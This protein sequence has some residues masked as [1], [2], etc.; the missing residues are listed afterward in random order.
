[1]AVLTGGWPLIDRALS[2]RE[3]LPGGALLELGPASGTA[4][5]RVVGEGWSLSKAQS[6]PS[7]SYALSRDGVDV[8]AGYVDLTTTEAGAGRL[9]TGLRRV[10]SVADADS[11]LGA[12]HS[13][14]SAGGARGSTGTLTRGGRTGTATVWLR[15]DETCAVEITV[16]AKPG[17]GADAMAEA[18]ALVRGVSFPQEAG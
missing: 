16:L 3:R 6:D 7:F 5:L 10:Q 15:P 13:A 12:P 2:D 18:M 8:V 4:V 1:M 14:T 11:R 9:W 17:A